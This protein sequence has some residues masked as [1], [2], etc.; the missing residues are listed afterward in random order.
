MDIIDKT[1]DYFAK[2]PLRVLTLLGG[3]GGLA[4]WLSL[5]KNRARLRIRILKEQFLANSDQLQ[6]IEFE[7]ESLGA[8]PTSLDPRIVLTGYTPKRE[9][10]TFEYRIESQD[11][12]LPPHVPK[13]LKATTKDD[14]VLPF[15]WY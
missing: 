14:H 1:L 8:M 15:L 9:L 5:Y 2:D 3:S 10:R 4:Y 6:C 11:R 13:L 7:A 12:S